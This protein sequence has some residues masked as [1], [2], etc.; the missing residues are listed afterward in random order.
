[1]KKNG[2]PITRSWLNL[3]WCFAGI[4]P[5][6]SSSPGSHRCNR[7]DQNSLHC[8]CSRDHD[9]YCRCRSHCHCSSS[10]HSHVRIGTCTHLSCSIWDRTSF[11]VKVELIDGKASFSPFF[12]VLSLLVHS[13]SCQTDTVRRC[14]WLKYMCTLFYFSSRQICSDHH[15][16]SSWVRVVA[17]TMLP[18]NRLHSCTCT[19]GFLCFVNRC[20]Q[21]CTVHFCSDRTHSTRVHS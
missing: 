15:C 9:H 21:I 17:H 1:M 8:I 18:Y 14:I 6:W 19:R 11:C 12:L 2:M 16:N 10:C 3:L 20:H 7:L 13:C 4:C 5:Y